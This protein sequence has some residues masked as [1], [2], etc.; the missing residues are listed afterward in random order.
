MLIGVLPLVPLERTIC[1]A[2]RLK[3]ERVIT[4]DPRD[5]A[6]LADRPRPYRAWM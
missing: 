6:E 4:T 5:V 3:F 2:P 1:C